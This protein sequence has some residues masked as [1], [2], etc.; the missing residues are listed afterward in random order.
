MEDGGWRNATPISGFPSIFH[1]P[2]SILASPS[3]SHIGDDDHW[4]E[5]PAG[6]DFRRRRRGR[7]SSPFA[8]ISPFTMYSKPAFARRGGS[9]ETVGATRASFAETLHG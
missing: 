4:P 5:F 3:L 9:R 6:A 2:S 8:V 7:D 1:P